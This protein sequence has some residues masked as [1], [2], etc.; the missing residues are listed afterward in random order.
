MRASAAAGAAKSESPMSIVAS[1]AAPPAAHAE[2]AM[3]IASPPLRAR[4]KVRIANVN[5]GHRRC[6]AAAHAELAITIAVTAACGRRTRRVANVNARLGAA[7]ARKV[8]IAN[9]NRGHRRCGAPHTP[10]RQCQ[11][12]PPPLL[13]R[14]TCELAMTIAVTAAVPPR[15]QSLAEGRPWRG[16]DHSPGKPRSGAARG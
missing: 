9:V 7:G 1:A 2:L 10:N 12:W 5:R 11:S 4:R 15:P 13:R 16:E 6:S 14:G 8:R 3:T